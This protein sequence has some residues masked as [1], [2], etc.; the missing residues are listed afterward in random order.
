[1]RGRK[2]GPLA[3]LRFL[4]QFPTAGQ[5]SATWKVLAIIATIVLAYTWA[6]SQIHDVALATVKAEGT[7][8]EMY[9]ATISEINGAINDLSTSVSELKGDQKAI[10][11]TVGFLKDLLREVREEQRKLREERRR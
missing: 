1:M 10:L 6:D 4:P 11:E 7:P 3:K 8:R 5:F 9:S 2:R